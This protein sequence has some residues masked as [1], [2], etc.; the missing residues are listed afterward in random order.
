MA[1]KAKLFQIEDIATDK[2]LGRDTASTGDI[3]EIGVSGGIEFT[4]SGGIQTSA[5]TGD[6]TKTAGGTALT[7]ATVNSNVGSFGS[8]TQ[9]ATFTVNAKG[10]TTAAGN[11]TIAIPASAVTDFSEAV[12]DRVATLIQNGTGITWSY[13]DGSNTL[14][15][16]VTI[17]QYTDE[18]AQ[19]AVGAMVDANS[20]TYT[21]GTPLLAVKRQMSITADTSGIKLSGDSATPGNS[22]LYGTDGSGTKGWYD[23]PSG[24][25]SS[26]GV[27]GAVQ[28]SG[29]S[30]AFSSDASNFFWDDSINQLQLDGGT[31]YGLLLKGDVAGINVDPDGTAIAG[32]FIVLNGLV[33]ATGSVNINLSNT[34]VGSTSNSR[35]LLSTASG[36][37]DPYVNLSTGDAGYIIGVDNSG[38]NK[39]YMGLGSNPS[40]MTTA[41]ITFEGSA[42]GI[43]Q[44][45]PTAKLH[46]GAGTATAGTAP[47]KLTSGTALTTPEDGV[48]E[49]HSSHIYFTIGSTRYQLDQ[50]S[51]SISDGDKGDITVSSSGTV[52]TIDAGAV[53]N[54]KI[55]DVSAAKITSGTITGSLVLTLPAAGTY[56]TA[57]N[58]SDIALQVSDSATSTTIFSKDGT[59]YVS[60]DNTQ[61]TIG[62]GTSQMIYIDG[63]LRI[64]DSDATHFVG[65]QTPATGSLTT[66]YTL[67]LPT[68]DGNPSQVLT[69]DGSGGLSW[70]T[71]S[72]ATG[73]VTGPASAVDNQIALFNLTTGKVIKAATSSGIAVL[74]SGVLSTTTAPSGDFVGTTDTQTLTNKRIN[75]RVTSTTSTT[76]PTPNIAN[77]DMYILTALAGNATFGSPTGT[78]VQG[79]NLVIRIKDNG[80]SRTLSWNSIYRGIGLTLPTTTVVNKTMYLGFKYNSTDTKWDLIASTIEA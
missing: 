77:E 37:G 25:G 42:V 34:N 1:T 10:L 32:A 62:S 60:A 41:N 79:N 19:D 49:Y 28:F 15:P 44:T 23:Q 78:P 56:T 12:D 26:S 69:T 21:D 46:V 57:Y 29:G 6:A 64:Y 7:L 66:S 53:N 36:G 3:E 74:T 40:S 24:G 5:F 13:N 33:D 14:T 45:S 16:T 80:T 30:G 76:T 18:L 9:V 72:S 27:T 67:T 39:L 31:S 43:L 38:G 17:T 63:V 51:A 35:L 48:I 73:D 54:A 71:P 2:L 55:S 59:Q 65:I 20:L 47:I 4:G 22:K 8:A 52:W 61:V 75:P 50:Q 58:G 11:T 70:S 68:T